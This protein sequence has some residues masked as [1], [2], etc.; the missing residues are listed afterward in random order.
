L[1]KTLFARINTKN[2]FMKNL[3]RPIG[4]CLFSL[5]CLQSCHK[6]ICFPPEAKTYPAYFVTQSSAILSGQVD[7]TYIADFEFGETTSYGKTLNIPTFWAGALAPVRV[8]STLTELSPNTT[9]HYRLK[10]EGS[11]SCQASYGIDVSFTT[12]KVGENGINLNSN[13]TYDSV[14]DIDGNKYKTIKIGT[15]TWMA[16]N[17]RVI[18]FNDNTSIPLVSGDWSKI[19]TMTPAYT[20]YNN[21]SSLYKNSIGAAYNWYAVNTNKLCPTGWHV[22]TDAEWTTL[23]NYLGGENVAGD[24]LRETGTSHWFENKGATNESGF[25]ALPG[26]TYSEGLVLHSI[27]DSGI[28]WS[29]TESDINYVWIRTLTGFGDGVGRFADGFKRYGYS[30]RCVKD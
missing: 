3:V 6:K 8:S 23:T 18:R 10:A 13:L 17:L 22:P 1:E 9:Y 19:T 27:G 2:I 28:W 5:L 29:S 21:D 25:T 11:G 26:F 30:I 20:W 12:L 24:K 16:E 15:Q 4:L 7:N 14:I